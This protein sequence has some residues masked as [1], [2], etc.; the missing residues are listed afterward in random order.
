MVQK[1]EFDPK[2]LVSW[3][4]LLLLLAMMISRFDQGMPLGENAP[5]IQKNLLNDPSKE[6]NIEALKGKVVILDFWATWCG[7]CQST[8]PAL[9]QVYQKY[10]DENWLWIGTVNTDEDLT[11]TQIKAFIDKRKFV[12]PVVTDGNSQISMK[13]E[14]RS[15]PTLV[16][17]DKD[18]RIKHSK[19][20]VT[21]RNP[22]TI[23]DEL[24]NLIESMR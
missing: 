1:N 2:Q 3:L 8:L 17:I 14:V 7:P 4:I 19:I 13:Y 18:G 16:V 11:D 5:Q 24:V 23:Y 21:S 9:N 12:F 15:L 20:G 10:K 6:L 22:Q